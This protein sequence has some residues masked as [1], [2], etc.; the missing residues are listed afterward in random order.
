MRFGFAVALLAVL[1]T[2]VPPAAAQ[3][4][5]LGR[6]LP[7]AGASAA[8]P[9]LPSGFYVEDAAGGVAFNTPVAVAFAPDGRMFVAEKRGVV[10]VV[11]DGV[12]LSTP[13]I[14]LQAEV[15][16]HHDRGLLG[17]TIDGQGRVF[18]LYTVDRDGSGDY[19]RFDVFGRLT[20]Y[21]PLASDANRADPASRRVLVGQTMAEG[22]P[23]CYFSH[24]VGTV[25]I[26]ADGTLLVGAGD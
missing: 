18:L 3:R 11:V 20:R 8:P 1:T 6:A 15:L 5:F 23:S 10:W 9:T 26:G 12:R 4:Q 2:A 24:T 16:D 13:F 14:D 19:S 25:A 17:M 22:F 21:S 7:E